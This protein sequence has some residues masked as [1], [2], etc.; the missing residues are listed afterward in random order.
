MAYPKF[1]PTKEFYL[2]YRGRKARLG[3]K[4]VNVVYYPTVSRGGSY[5]R[6]FRFYQSEWAKLID[7]RGAVSYDHGKTWHKS[8][9]LARAFKSTK[10]KMRLTSSNH[11][12]LAL[13]GIQAINRKWDGPG[14][15]WHR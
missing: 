6:G 7:E 1:K 3:K 10:G 12:E 13:E 14:Y 9:F 2:K 11:G 15:R 4:V 5:E 8:W